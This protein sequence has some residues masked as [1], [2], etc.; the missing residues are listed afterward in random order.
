MSV[1]NQEKLTEARLFGTT[2]FV[3]A[4][5]GVAHF[6]AGP[7]WNGPCWHEFHEN[8]FYF[9]FYLFSIFLMYKKIFFVFL[10]QFFF[11]F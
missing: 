3:V 10:I 9:C 4:L 1:Q 11:S 5:F 6:V 2:H 8:N 7:F